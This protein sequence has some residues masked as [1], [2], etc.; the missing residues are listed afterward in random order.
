MGQVINLFQAVEEKKQI[1]RLAE[2]AVYIHRTN[3]E[4]EIWKQTHTVMTFRDLSKTMEDERD[5]FIARTMIKEEQEK[6]DVLMNEYN[7][8]YL[9]QYGPA[10][11]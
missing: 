6:L 5:R 4:H 9:E 10:G 1:R 8:H 2:R 7:A 11:H 3:L